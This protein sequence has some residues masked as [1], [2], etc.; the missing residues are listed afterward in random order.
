MIPTAGAA[1]RSTLIV[2]R[3]AASISRESAAIGRRHRGAEEERLA[4]GRQVPQHAPDVGQEA[5]VEHPVGLV[6]HQVLDAGKLGV[7][8]AEVVEQ[9]AGRGDDARRR[10]CGTRAPGVPIPTPPKIAAAGDRRVHGQVVEVLEDLRGQLA[11]RRQDERARGAAG[12]VDQPVE[13]GQQERRR[14][15]AP[16]HR[17]GEHVPPLERGRDGVG[18]DRCRTGEP[19]LLDSLEEARVELEAS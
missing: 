11:G 16:G 17:A 8:R 13:D 5:H 6:E 15:A 3:V 19:E 18:L 1:L 7:G 14:L 12:L 2:D 4:P 10:R 9:P